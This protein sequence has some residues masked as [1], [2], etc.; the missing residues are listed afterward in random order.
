MVCAHSDAGCHS[1][2]RRP[3]Q[4]PRLRSQLTPLCGRRAAVHLL[5]QWPNPS[6]TSSIPSSCA[7]GHKHARCAPA[8]YCWLLC[9]SPPPI[10]ERQGCMNSLVRR[11]PVTAQ[12]VWPACASSRLKCGST[13]TAG[14]CWRVAGLAPGFQKR[15]LLFPR[16]CLPPGHQPCAT[17][18][19]V[20]RWR[21]QVVAVVVQRR[22]AT[23]PLLWM[24][25]RLRLTRCTSCT[26]RCAGCCAS[27]FVLTLTGGGWAAAR[28]PAA[29]S[30]SPPS[31][32][33]MLVAAQMWP[34]P[35]LARIIQ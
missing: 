1:H 34:Q 16:R 33:D 32:S 18:S 23:T 30:S 9:V 19:G 3:S 15:V 21:R 12:P 24:L 4:L 35:F 25:P 20:R 6:S 17:Q 10:G 31:D 7:G 28:G 2:W 26:T 5:I 8:P 13:A 27:K 11:A 29:P 22:R 14:A